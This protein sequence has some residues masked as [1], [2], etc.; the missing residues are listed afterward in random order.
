[1][2][3]ADRA[4][5]DRVTALASTE[6]AWCAATLAAMHRGAATARDARHYA[7]IAAGLRLPVRYVNGCMIAADSTGAR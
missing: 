7:D 3:K 5:L 2:T 1:M 6:P 4:R